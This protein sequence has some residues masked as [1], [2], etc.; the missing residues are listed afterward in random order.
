[1][2]N[3][4]NYG[5]KEAFFVLNKI[6]DHMKTSPEGNLII[7]KISSPHEYEYQEKISL[8]KEDEI[9]HNL[10]DWGLIKIESREQIE[11][12]L[13]YYLLPLPKFKK[14]FIDHKNILI[15]E[16]IIKSATH[17]NL[18][19]EKKEN[20]LKSITL[21]AKS[22]NPKEGNIYVVFDDYFE[23]P[24]RYVAVSTK[25]EPTY[26][27]KL[28]DIAYQPQL[29]DKKVEYNRNLADN[30]NNGLFKNKKAYN[31]IKTNKIKK[32][33]LVQGSEDK[34]F[35]VLKN[36]VSIKTLLVAQ[37]PVQHQSLYK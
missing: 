15:E 19:S 24:I 22:L 12:E 23:N 3:K 36:D 20:Q 28:F 26:M 18:S 4:T 35:L 5:S 14:T 6:H 2:E 29:P 13:V 9:L 10:R 1:M 8:C 11:N 27:K 30:I 21:V 7:Y 25:G 34:K 33:T 17:N 16:K 32:P 31:Y 37:S